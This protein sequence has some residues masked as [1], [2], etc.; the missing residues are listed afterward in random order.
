MFEA[1]KDMLG[2]IAPD[3]EIDGV[4]W[5]IITRPNLLTFTF[6]SLSNRITDKEDLSLG[7]VVLDALVEFRLAAFPPVVVPRNGGYGRTA[8]SGPGT[9]GNQR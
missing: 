1:P 2:T 7:T 4:S 5:S 6:P 8:E 3:A 9:Q